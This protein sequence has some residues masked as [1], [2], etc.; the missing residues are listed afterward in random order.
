M[1]GNACINLCGGGSCKVYEGKCVVCVCVCINYNKGAVTMHV[2]GCQCCE[3]V[4][5]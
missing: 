5:V 4:C 2:V 3:L 1:C